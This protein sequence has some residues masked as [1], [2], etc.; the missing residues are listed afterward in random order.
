VLRDPDV[1]VQLDAIL[2]SQE[3]IMTRFDDAVALWAD[4]ATAQKDLIASL[5]AQLVEA[6]AT[7]AQLVATDAVEDAAQ[8]EALSNQLAD[9]LAAALEALKGAP[10]EP[11][12]VVPEEPPVE[13][14][15]VEEEPQGPFAN[16]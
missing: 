7:A 13:E 9:Q 11:P 1:S 8:A 5:Q 14:P 16:A 3:M 12:P 15:P 6:Q 4:Y 2:K 10:E